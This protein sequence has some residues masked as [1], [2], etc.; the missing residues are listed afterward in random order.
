MWL[1]VT[2]KIAKESMIS[3]MLQAKKSIISYVRH[4]SKYKVV[5]LLLKLY[6]DIAPVLWNIFW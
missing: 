6:L 3:N 5:Q 4:N 2:D 1:G